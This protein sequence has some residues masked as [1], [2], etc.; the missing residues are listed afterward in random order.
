MAAIAVMGAALPAAADESAEAIPGRARARPMIEACLEAAQTVEAMR[1][2][3]R[4]VFNPCVEEEE[5]LQ[6]T[7]GLV[8]CNSRE[9][10]AWDALLQAR[11]AE[12]AQRD[13]YRAE[14]LAAADTA[15]RAW[16]EA[17]CFYHREEAQGGSAEG[18]ITT[19]CNADLTADRVI[20]LTLQTRGE[21]PY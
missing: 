12:L 6:S 14:A 19:E 4:I 5:N 8:M 16:V 20:G 11:T 10:E 13:A 18:V 21:L 3:K 17:E 15:W 7:H 2:C 9:G 1:A